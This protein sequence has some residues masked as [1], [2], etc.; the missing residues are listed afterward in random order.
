MW[1]NFFDATRRTVNRWAKQTLAYLE[2]DGLDEEDWADASAGSSQDRGFETFSRLKE[3]MPHAAWLEQEQLFAME[4][5]PSTEGAFGGRRIEA[6]AFTVELA[7]VAGADQTMEKS[8]RSILALMPKNTGVQII[9]MGD[10]RIHSYLDHF[11]AMRDSD[12]SY[13]KMA[14]RRVQWYL[15]GAYGG[16]F[17]TLPYRL[18]K[19]RLVMAFTFPVD[20]L[21]DN[22]AID[23]VVSMRS[24]IMGTLGTLQFMPRLWKPADW[25][26]WMELVGNPEQ[27][28]QQK[29]TRQRHY[30]THDLMRDQA[31]HSETVMRVRPK[32]LVFG[33]AASGGK[34]N[35]PED[36]NV[37]IRAMSAQD[38]PTHFNLAQ[39]GALLGD[40]LRQELQYPC[41]YVI[42]LGI[43]AM[44]FEHSKSVAMM[45]G[46]RAT[47]NATSPMA[48]F[49]PE[50]AEKKTDWDNVLASFDKGEGLVHL[51]HQVLLIDHE[52]S[53]ERSERAA[54]QIWRSRSFALRVDR[55]MQLQAWLSTIPMSLTPSKQED[56]RSTQRYSTKTIGNAANTAPMI[57]EWTGFG[58]PVLVLWGRQGQCMGIDFFA[59]PEG[60]YNMAIAAGSGAGKSVLGNELIA[61]VRGMG[62]KAYVI[63]A[64]RSYEKPCKTHNGQFIEFTPEHTPNFNPF[65]MITDLTDEEAFKDAVVMIAQIVNSMAAP[66]RLLSDYEQGIVE[67]VV[68]EEIND[69]RNLGTITGVYDRLISFRNNQTNEVEPVAGQLAQSMRS[70]TENGIFGKYFS[71]GDP[72]K[73]ESDYI[74]LELDGLAASPRLQSTVLMIM[75]FQITQAMYLDRSVRKIV[76][77]DEA[78]QLMRDGATA[79]FIETG[80][81]RIRKY[82]GQFGTI[83]QSFNDYFKTAASKAAYENSDWKISLRQPEEAWAQTFE[84]KHFVADAA[85]QAMLRSLR[86][87]AGKFSEI[88]IKMPQG[89]GV[90]R[91]ILDPYALLE[92][93]TKAEDFNAVGKYRNQGMSISEA[94]E[95]VIV[96]R[97]AA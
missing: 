33:V 50:Y 51:Y 63:D 21:D 90:G 30:N 8:L 24:T 25:L 59:N 94:I 38:Y 37:V 27:A 67:Q 84:A 64:G 16:L 57:G 72:V 54:E 92:Y 69:K 77:I 49:M 83:T 95:R 73:F 12:A 96:D 87:E 53:I 36:S 74:V 35:T 78:W 15:K 81:R 55:Y 85:Q 76:L 45:K 20:G 26:E 22:N 41:A 43:M 52:A 10:P 93:S 3:L 75:M 48:R 80:Y 5:S 89:W 65:P 46:A 11:I 91:L 97:A 82:N 23:N 86:T 2:E 6:M 68:Q 60:N 44:D 39:V 29:D 34:R 17:A 9:A 1:D 66:D 42:C 18:R 19:L 61:G 62:G 13:R 88:F 31:F 4:T 28:L 32:N 56:L 58:D 70:Y 40:H 71:A 7:P 14:Q 79:K 47:T